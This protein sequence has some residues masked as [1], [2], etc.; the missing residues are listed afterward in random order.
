ML[1][2]LYGQSLDGRLTVAELLDGK[3]RLAQGGLDTLITFSQGNL[4]MLQWQDLAAALNRWRAI[5]S[6]GGPGGII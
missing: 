1:V 2:Q 3:A 6:R 4:T 5:S